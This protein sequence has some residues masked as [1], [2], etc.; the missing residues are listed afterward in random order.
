MGFY[1]ICVEVVLHFSMIAQK[2][3]SRR[4]FVN[5]NYYYTGQWPRVDFHHFRGMSMALTI[6]M[7]HL[8]NQKILGIIYS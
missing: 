7:N 4:V 1:R 5:K 3:L 2:Y 6:K 8:P